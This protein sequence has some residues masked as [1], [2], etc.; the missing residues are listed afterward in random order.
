MNIQHKQSG[1][2]VPVLQYQPLLKQLRPP[3]M[4]LIFFSWNVA[5]FEACPQLQNPSINLESPLVLSD[6]GSRWSHSSWNFLHFLHLVL[7]QTGCC[8]SYLLFNLFK[9]FLLLRAL[10]EIALFLGHS[11][12]RGCNQTV[13]CNTPSP[14]TSNT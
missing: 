4:L 6:R 11:I 3:P 9:V 14:E 10:C 8:T 2:R 7:H 1:T 5:G 13:I 12:E